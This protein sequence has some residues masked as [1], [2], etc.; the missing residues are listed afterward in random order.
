MDAQLPQID[1]NVTPKSKIHPSTVF[2]LGNGFYSFKL[3]PGKTHTVKRGTNLCKA[4]GRMSHQAWESTAKA[5]SKATKSAAKATGQATKTATTI[6]PLQILLN[7]L[8]IL[9]LPFANMRGKDINFHLLWKAGTLLLG[10]TVLIY[11]TIEIV[12]AK[13]I[14]D[15]SDPQA[16]GF[17]L[18]AQTLIPGA[19]ALGAISMIIGG[20]RLHQGKSFYK[21]YEEKF[22][23]P[24]AFKAGAK[25][26]I[27]DKV[28]SLRDCHTNIG[29]FG[30]IGTGKMLCNYLEINSLIG[31]SPQK[32]TVG[33]IKRGDFIETP[34]G[35]QRVEKLIKDRQ[36]VFTLTLA[37]GKTADCCKNHLWDIRIQGEEGE[38]LTETGSISTLLKEGKEILCPVWENGKETLERITSI[39]PTN[40]WEDMT[41]FSLAGTE[42]RFCLS[43]GIITHNCLDPEQEI[44]MYD[45]RIKK[46][47]EV[48]EGDLLMGPDGKPR[49]IITTSTGFGP[50]YRIIPEH[51]DPW[52][53]NDVHVMTLVDPKTTGIIPEE[54]NRP[55][56]GLPGV[57]IDL[58]IYLKL[59]PEEQNSLHLIKHDPRTGKT[60]TSPWK[61]QEIGEGPYCGFT[62]DGDGRFLLG[63]F[64]VTH[65]TVSVMVPLMRQ[66]FQQLNHETDDPDDDLQK[67]AALILDE[68][69]D[70]IDSTVA[71]LILAGRSIADLIIID[72]DLDLFRY[73]PL[74]PGQSAD[75]NAAKLAKVQKILG[76]SGGGNDAFWEQ[77]S[78]LVIKNFLRL[79]EVYKS[80]DKIGVDDIARFM[81]D[82]N[83]GKILCDDIEKTIEAKKAS[84]EI[85]DEQYGSLTDAISTVMNQW[86]HLSQNTKS[87]LKNTI[88]NM[89]GPIASNPRLQ[90]V[91]CR[92]TNFS[93]K[94]L[95]NKGKVVLFRGSGIDK[96]TAK[97]ICVCL[98]SDFQTWQK[99]R[100]GSQAKTYGLN[101]TRTVLFVCDEYQEFVSCGGEGDETFYGVSRSAKTCAIVATQ[102]L[103]SLKTAIKN[104]E[105]TNTLIQNITTWIFLRT[106]DKDTMELGELWAGQSKQEDFST[107]QSTSGFLETAANLSGGGG[108]K[109]NSINISKKLEANF[110]KDDF[111][112]L[113]TI[114][115]EKSAKGPYYS[116]AIVYHYHDTDIDAPS[117]CYKTKLKHYY[118]SISRKEATHQVSLLDNL[119]YDRNWQRKAFQRGLLLIA[120]AK[121]DALK[122]KERF[123]E[124]LKHRTQIN[125]EEQLSDHQKRQEQ[126][127]KLARERMEK[128]NADLEET[129]DKEALKGG[130]SFSENT[131]LL[132]AEEK[133][134]LSKRRIELLHLQSKA[135]TTEEEQ[136]IRAELAKI[137]KRMSL[138]LLSTMPTSKVQ[139]TEVLEAKQNFLKSP[140]ENGEPV[141]QSQEPPSSSSTEGEENDDEELADIFGTEDCDE[142]ELQANI[143]AK[144]ASIASPYESNE[145]EENKALHVPALSAEVTSPPTPNT[146]ETKEEEEEDDTPQIE[147]TVPVE[148]YP[149]TDDYGESES[150]DTEEEVEDPLE[151]DSFEG[152]TDDEPPENLGVTDTPDEDDVYGGISGPPGEEEDNQEESEKG[153]PFG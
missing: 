20:I 36:Q 137:T 128:Q 52:V 123:E 100:N 102:S 110:R 125:K 89:L 31:D 83:L 63:D 77:T 38:I 70:F 112:K 133:E 65:N 42:H 66:F 8:D 117:R 148:D 152:P 95:P 30:G 71:E 86:I 145:P 45:G 17:L 91:F 11:K 143:L 5:T 146:T 3:R 74:D 94:D 118:G 150:Q 43:N 88:D 12:G 107:S 92:D 6:W 111:S 68:K 103:N 2:K 18:L 84:H 49:R 93:F 39:T 47:R 115:A 10:V 105:Q 67:V 136:R 97:L 9:S 121:E 127:K 113:V 28:L 140:Q 99:R 60:S 33:E 76:N 35:Y 61:A 55:V 108:G 51:G 41:C 58:D 14:A 1:S 141:N 40:K 64:T 75:E 151:E 90:K 46:V 82:D 109:D 132:S 120:A 149:T 26:Y 129:S 116:E 23:P 79:L 87:I 135:Q 119:L 72:P 104:P 15:R 69:G 80:K 37:T 29:A 19:M 59:R 124:A 126:R 62:L 7:L 32:T 24:P 142:E 34:Q 106:T 44:L 48:Q 78:Q 131:S 4:I 138:A 56:A 27:G 134:A 25:F 50:L 54:K 53:C 96:S 139:E 144:G 16:A 98:K 122:A 114:T 13:F 22:N 73:N 81:R 21:K 57:D 101:Q 147:D 153:N 130:L 85:S